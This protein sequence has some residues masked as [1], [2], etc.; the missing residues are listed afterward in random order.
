MSRPSR[1]ELMVQ[2]ME[3]RS[4]KA[5]DRERRSHAIKIGLLLCAYGFLM[6]IIGIFISPPS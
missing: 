2:D 3:E 5:H 4:Q 1:Y 6:L